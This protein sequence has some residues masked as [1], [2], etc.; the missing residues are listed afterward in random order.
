MLVCLMAFYLVLNRKKN[1]LSYRQ[2]DKRYYLLYV[3]QE[4]DRVV[5]FQLKT[6]TKTKPSAFIRASSRNKNCGC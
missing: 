1:V 4:D 2:L 5:Y 3:G 6:A